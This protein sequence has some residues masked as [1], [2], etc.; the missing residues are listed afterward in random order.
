MIRT[1]DLLAAIVNKLASLDAQRDQIDRERG[2]YQRILDLVQA[3][4]RRLQA[5]LDRA[6]RCPA[7]GA[8]TL[9]LTPLHQNGEQ[10]V[11]KN[12][13]ACGFSDRD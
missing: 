5:V 9:S 7:C 4:H 2:Y 13:P 3:E 1:E 10:V 11:L 8:Q 6:G 12:C